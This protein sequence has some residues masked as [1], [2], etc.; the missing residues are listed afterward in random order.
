[1]TLISPH[2]STPTSRLER[3][4]RRARATA[5][6]TLIEVLVS[7]LM[8][9]LIASAAAGALIATTHFSGN[10]RLSSQADELATQ[11]QERLRG[12][13]DEQ[14]TGLNQT[15]PVTLNGTAFHVQS[16][17]TAEDTTG[18]SNCSTTAAA[19]YRIVSTVTWAGTPGSTPTPVVEESLLSR[20]VSGD[21]RTLVTD[22]TGAGL[23]GVTVTAT[24]ASPQSAP[25]DS[26]G[27]V[28]FAGLTPGSYT[29]TESLAGY[30]NPQ[31]QTA[32]NTQGQAQWKGSAT[33]ASSGVSTATGLPT[34]L[35]MPGSVA[36]TFTTALGSATPAVTAEAAGISWTGS[37]ASGSDAGANPAPATTSAPSSTFTTAPLF[38]FNTAST[39]SPPSYTGNYAVW[40]GRCPGQ[41]PPPGNL[42]T[43]TVPPGT[44]G[45]SQSITEPILYL[46][47]VTFKSSS[48]KPSDVRLT[49]SSSGCT[50]TWLASLTAQTSMPTNGWLGNPGQPYAASGTLTVCADYDYY[51]S[52][53]RT[54]TYYKG[55]A[56]TGNSSFAASNIA[57]QVPPITISTSTAGKC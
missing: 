37:D 3:V 6:F 40:G 54:W 42:T 45:V 55:T 43:A 33:V 23:P 52:T 16:V 21:L 13:S 50:D 25:T 24:G 11:D 4:R 35:G 31:G 22:Q 36:G 28:L 39:G 41:E 29:V 34:E 27:C 38:P 46:G 49:F 10:Q 12:M 15:R 9:G 57:N 56:S 17:A 8:V 47:N 48:V 14:L 30:V 51:N 1:M 2:A 7:A 26:T 20:P 5:G 44:S 19:Y 53:K 18:N 32:T